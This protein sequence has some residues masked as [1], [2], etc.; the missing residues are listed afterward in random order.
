MENKKTGIK[1]LNEYLSRLMSASSYSIGDYIF[2]T[3][4]RLLWHENESIRLTKKE[5]YLLVLFSTH[6]NEFLNRVE[7]FNIIWKNETYSNSRSLDVYVFK[8]RKLLSKDANI[9]ILNIHG[10][11]YKMIVD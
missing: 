10:K 6:V 11:G 1:E 7:I 9:L 3:Q 2:D 5:S 8:L 4:K